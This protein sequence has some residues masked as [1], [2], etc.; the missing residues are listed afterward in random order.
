MNG[1]FTPPFIAPALPPAPVPPKLTPASAVACVEPEGGCW[2][3]PSVTQ[4][5]VYEGLVAAAAAVKIA[6][7]PTPTVG[8]L[9]TGTTHE[10]LSAGPWYRIWMCASTV[11]VP[12]AGSP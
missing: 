1:T 7:V 12:F 8:S 6:S 3:V 5:T 4:L 9:S 10:N 11:P 2:H